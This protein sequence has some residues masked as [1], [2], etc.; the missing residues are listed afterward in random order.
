MGDLA[1]LFRGAPT[2][3]TALLLLEKVILNMKHFNERQRC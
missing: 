3:E 1:I 2:T